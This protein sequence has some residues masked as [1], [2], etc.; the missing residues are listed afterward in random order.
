MRKANNRL[1][2]TRAKKGTGY[3]RLLGFMVAVIV[4]MALAVP[5]YASGLEKTSGE[6]QEAGYEHIQLNEETAAAALVKAQKQVAGFFE[7]QGEAL[8]DKE[9]AELS[10]T[11]EDFIHGP[12]MKLALRDIRDLAE[13]LGHGTALGKEAEN[14]AVN[15][16]LED[17]GLMG[18][19]L[20]HVLDAAVEASTFRD[21]VLLDL[22]NVMLHD[23]WHIH[24]GL[25]NEIGGREGMRDEMFNRYGTGTG[26]TGGDGVIT[27][28]GDSSSVMSGSSGWSFE[29]CLGKGCLSIRGDRY[30]TS[31]DNSSSDSSSSETPAPQEPGCVPWDQRTPETPEPECEEEY[32]GD[33]DGYYDEP[34]EIRE[35]PFDTGLQN[36]GLQTELRVTP[37]QGLICG[38]DD[39]EGP[40]DLMGMV[41]QPDPKAEVP[42]Y[43]TCD[44]EDYG[45]HGRY[46]EPEP[47][48]TI[49]NPLTPL[50]YPPRDV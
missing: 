23:I 19:Y 3:R 25:M 44:R 2:Y 36:L 4:M 31:S 24:G 8:S 26:H 21:A 42:G 47:D 48:L 17:G 15:G 16:T 41:D 45:D 9:A 32:P 5:A 20:D 49:S 46:F 18:F 10:G 11:L 30:N 39:D 1:E 27:F 6:K 14:T 50:I 40:R 34:K 43:F 7:Q 37:N 33:P 38:D 29:V 22:V 28:Q 35:F 12:F 13:V